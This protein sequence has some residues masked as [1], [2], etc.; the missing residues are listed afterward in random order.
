MWSHSPL[1]CH[2]RPLSQV[3]SSVPRSDPVSFFP[4][5]VPW[6]ALQ[7]CVAAAILLF[8]FSLND[9][10]IPSLQ[11]HWKNPLSAFSVFLPNL[12][13]SPLPTAFPLLNCWLAAAFPSLPLPPHSFTELCSCLHNSSSCPAARTVSVGLRE[14][15]GSWDVQQED[16]ELCGWS[17][18]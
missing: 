17:I 14:G 10:L 13:T 18:L 9:H 4:G 12:P 1:S 3:L 7:H 6:N 5:S 2:S 15:Q 16:Q 8:L 11:V